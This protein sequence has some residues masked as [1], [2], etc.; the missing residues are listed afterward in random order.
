MEHFWTPW[1]YNYVTTA[2]RA[3]RPGIPDELSTWPGDTGCVFCN[4]IASVDHAIA[5]GM[6]REQAEAAAGL[7][8]RARHCFICLNA[9]PYTS[10]HVM[11]M[12]YAHLDRLAALPV[13]AAHELVDLAQL[14]ERVLD[15]VYTPHGFNFGM[16]VGQAAGAGVAGHI[17]LHALPRWIGDTSFTTTVAETRVLPEDLNT[18][19]RRLRAAFAE[20]A[21]EPTVKRAGTD[22]A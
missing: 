18:T 10:G 13:E 1:R 14:T 6:N 22:Q 2:D 8:F 21:S 7:V 4:L 20:L 12:P 9:F 3:V 16:N 5:Q 11:A 15:R 17:H 19:W